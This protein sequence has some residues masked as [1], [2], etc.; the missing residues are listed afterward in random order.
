MTEPDPAD[1][2]RRYRRPEGAPHRTVVSAGKGSPN[3]AARV[4]PPGSSR[5]SSQ[6]YDALFGRR[7]SSMPLP[8]SLV[9][10]AAQAMR[11]DAISNRRLHPKTRLRMLIQ[12][13]QMPRHWIGRRLLQ[14][15]AENRGREP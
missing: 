8:L 3:S 4:T 2:I 15:A 5:R 14:L 12:A 6:A 9:L 13:E 10:Q 11:E 1:E 7:G